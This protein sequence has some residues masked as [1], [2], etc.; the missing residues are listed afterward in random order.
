[1]AKQLYKDAEHIADEC[2][3]W[4]PTRE[5]WEARFDAAFAQMETA[6]ARSFDRSL[7]RLETEYANCNFSSD[8][9]TKEAPYRGANRIYPLPAYVDFV[10]STAVFRDWRPQPVRAVAHALVG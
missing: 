1:M 9:N 6:V 10:S 2:E 5:A 4:L 7:Q 3:G 8:F